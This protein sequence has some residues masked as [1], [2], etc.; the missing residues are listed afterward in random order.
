[1]FDQN[2]KA[3]IDSLIYKT[4]YFI[5]PIFLIS[6]ILNVQLAKPKQWYCIR[7]ELGIIN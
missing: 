1:M 5:V 4:L 3:P 2:V 7:R 6:S